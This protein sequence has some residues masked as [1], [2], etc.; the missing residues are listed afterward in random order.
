MQLVR[1]VL[2]LF[3]RDRHPLVYGAQVDAL[4]RRKRRRN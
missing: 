2:R 3:E 1:A 4:A